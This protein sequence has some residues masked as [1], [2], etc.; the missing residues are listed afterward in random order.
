MCVFLVGCEAQK[1]TTQTPIREHTG[2]P[3]RLID[4][5]SPY[6]LQHAYNPVDWYPWGDEALQKAQDE[7]KLMVISVGYSACHWCHVMERESYE[8]SAV[9]AIMNQHYVSI[10]VDR[11]ERPDVD[12]IYMNAAFLTL[13]RGG[14]PL[15]AI[16]LPDGRPVY[17]GT[18]FPKDNW[19]KLLE[20]FQE[21]FEND[22]DGL[23]SQ[24][25]KITNQIKSLNWIAPKPDAADFDPAEMEIIGKKMLQQIDFKKGGLKGAPKF[26]MPNMYQFLLRYHLLSGDEQSLQAVNTTL[27]AIGYGG[28]NDHVGGGF[29]RYSTDEDWSVPHFEKMLYDNGQLVSTYADAYRVTRNPLYLNI[30]KQTLNFIEREMTSPEGGFYSSLDADSEGEEGKFYVWQKSELDS[31]IG[32]NA[33]VFNEFYSVTQKGNWEGTNVLRVSSPEKV[34][35]QFGMDNEMFYDFMRWSKG[36]VLEARNTRIRPGLD[37]KVLTS[38]NALMLKGYVDAYRALGDST[39]REVAI[40]NANLIADKMMNEDG[41][42]FRNYKDGKATINAFLDD[43][44]FTIE[45]FIALYQVTFDERWLK[46]AQQLADYTIAQFYDEQSGL[47]NYKSKLDKALIADSKQIS[48]DVV[49]SSNSS[50]GKGLFLLG[51]YLYNEDYMDISKSML[52]AVLE[53]VKDNAN[54][55]SN[56]G[57]LFLYHSQPYYEVAIVGEDAEQLRQKLDQHF[58]PNVFYLGGRNEGTL[59]LLKNKLVEDA[60]YIYVCQDKVCKLPVQTV[61]EAEKLIVF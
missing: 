37:D 45:A 47:F 44:G 55:Y 49:P 54:F 12:Q 3:N 33:A 20:F 15:N 22:P 9:A 25:E 27:T 29:A 10:K 56:W 51:L 40:K 59:E 5:N 6:L 61:E 23:R 30:I 43:Y 16:A 50:M 24:A 17:A 58:R 7:K 34:R 8:D 21:Q 13:G 53:S 4:S 60:T 52:A 28:I 46:L 41:S 42:L 35:K 19:I 1:N 48:D 57:Q 36:K 2:T 26:P 14:W 38:W 11:E 18:Y 31:I 32:E 39:Y